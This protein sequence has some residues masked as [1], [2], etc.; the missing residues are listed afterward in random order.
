M[1]YMAG[2]SNNIR[3]IFAGGRNQP[4]AQYN[5]VIDYI[6]MATTGNATDF[7]DFDTIVRGAHGTASSTR[8]V[9]HGGQTPGNSFVNNIQYITIGSTGNATDFGDLTEARGHA[10]LGPTCSE[11]RGITMGGGSPTLR[12][13]IDYITIASAGDA[14][15]F[16]NLTAAVQVP[17]G[18][19]NNIRAIATGGEDAS[20]NVG[21]CDYVTIATT[22]DAADFGDLSSGS[23]GKQCGNSNAHG[24]L[25]G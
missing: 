21:N 15:D 5:N 13:T 3:G 7:G 18:L 14:T 8:G 16:G 22:G 24:G 10:A 20:G 11:T 4:A 19:S 25:Q 9:I 2:L 17:G 1:Y 23:T 6:T 12:N